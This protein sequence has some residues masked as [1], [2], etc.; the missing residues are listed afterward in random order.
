MVLPIHCLYPILAMLRLELAMFPRWP[1]D[2]CGWNSRPVGVGKTPVSNKCLLHMTL[3]TGSHIGKT[4]YM[5]QHSRKGSPT[6][7]LKVLRVS[8]YLHLK[9][10][11]D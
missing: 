9:K 10:G 1:Y 11:G 8:T 3:L 2:H 7:Q 5:K 4:K 6:N